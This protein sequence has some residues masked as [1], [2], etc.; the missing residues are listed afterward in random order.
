MM[1]AIAAS[2]SFVAV[3]AWAWAP[4]PAVAQEPEKPVVLEVGD[5]AP[6]FESVDDAGK[7]WTSSDHVGE[8]ILVVY[9][10]PKDMTPGCTK[11][12]QCY[13]DAMAEFKDKDVEVVGVSG[14][15]V[16]S[17]QEFKKAEKLNYT[18]LAD[19]EGKVAKAFGVK[20]LGGGDTF[21]AERWTF[22]IDQEGRIAYKDDNVK[23]DQ[24]VINVLKVVAKL[25][26]AA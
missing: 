7:P 17:H 13:R 25:K 10:Y 20:R 23:S 14:D 8:K 16:E 6:E 5:E 4:A 21:I 12:G 24:D 3:I 9:F 26:K 2:L 1:R 22:V 11:Q 15:T 19:P 18:L